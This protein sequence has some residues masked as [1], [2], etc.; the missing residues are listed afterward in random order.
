MKD[1]CECA[2]DHLEEIN[3]LLESMP[4]TDES[5]RASDIFSLLSDSSRLRIL[6][7]LCHSEQ[8]VTNIAAC[9]EMSSPAVS[10]HLRF[11]KQSKII[12]SEKRGKETF[13]KLADSEYATLAHKMIDDIFYLEC[14]TKI[15]K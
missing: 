11:L 8:C 7:L 15:V 1:L 14:P 9:V 3:S 4:S 6:W 13:Y 10:H 12:T 2:H 5:T